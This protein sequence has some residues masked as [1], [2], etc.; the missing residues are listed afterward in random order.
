MV[1][2]V[3]GRAVAT[4]TPVVEV[5]AGLPIG[6]HRFQLV[7]QDDGGLRSRPDQVVVVVARGRVLPTPTDLRDAIVR[8][9]VG[10]AAPATAP[11]RKRRKP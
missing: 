9:P 1:A 4:A 8:R 6:S 7:V 3:V 10:A 2:F 11:S 5:D